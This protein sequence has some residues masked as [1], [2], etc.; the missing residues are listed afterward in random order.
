MFTIKNNTNRTGHRCALTFGSPSLSVALCAAES[1]W[2]YLGLDLHRRA[3]HL[4]TVLLERGLD[5]LLPEPYSSFL[6]CVATSPPSLA[7]W[8]PSPD[9]PGR[10]APNAPQPRYR[11]S[12]IAISALWSTNFSPGTHMIRMRAS[13]V[14]KTSDRAPRRVWWLLDIIC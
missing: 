11:I 7:S 10:S 4:Q 6:S 8:L 14:P 5:H 3:T 13:C 9:F 1:A 12:V 2:E